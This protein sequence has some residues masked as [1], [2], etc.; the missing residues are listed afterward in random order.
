MNYLGKVIGHIQV[1]EFQKRGLPHAHILL[2][3]DSLDKPRTTNDYDAIVSAEIPD[4]EKFPLAY[5]TVTRHM[6][7]G[8]CGEYNPNAVCME[9]GVCTKH[10]PRSFVEGTYT[11]Q[12]GYPVYRRRMDGRIVRKAGVDLDNRWVVPH[13]V[14]LC[15]KYD[16]HINVEVCSTISVIKYLYKYVYKGHDCARVSV[17]SDNSENDNTE[18]SAPINEINMFLDARYDFN[19]SI[20]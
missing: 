18:G 14:Y 4:E 3:L 20:Y 19:L 6:I 2:I 9:H 13:N 10:Y 8:P 12:S 15:R 11:E 5:S 1:I 17:Q 7:H 16:A